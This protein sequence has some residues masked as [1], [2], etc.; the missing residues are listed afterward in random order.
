MSSDP[1]KRQI[2]S[3][4]RREGRVTRAQDRALDELL[5]RFGMDFDSTAPD[6]DAIF[7]REA[8]RVLEIGFGDGE[9]LVEIAKDNP[10]VDHLGIEV[11][12]PGVGHLLLALEREGLHNVRV[13][14]EDATVVVRALP[15]DSGK[16]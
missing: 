13:M 14:I 1:E 2:R 7:Q 3:F 5:P 9:A 8:P 6:F 15:P 4:V 11:H 12:R 16:L 10:D